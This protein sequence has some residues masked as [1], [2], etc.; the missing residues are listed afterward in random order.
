MICARDAKGPEGGP[1]RPRVVG[2]EEA[3]ARSKP[4]A[5]RRGA[6]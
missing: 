5:D 1:R 4:A 3:E 6:Q 2:D